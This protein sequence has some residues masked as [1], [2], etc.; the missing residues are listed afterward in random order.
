[1]IRRLY[2]VRWAQA[3]KPSIANVQIRTTTLANCKRAA[4][5]VAKQLG[6]TNTPR[7]IV[8]EGRVLESL[9]TGVSK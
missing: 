7:T 3:G 4:N 6:V 8:S 9:V 2:E 1:M 5:K